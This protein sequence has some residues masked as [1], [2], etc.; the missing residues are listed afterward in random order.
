MNRFDF[1]KAMNGLTRKQREVLERFLTGQ[2]D[3][4][5]ADN[6]ICTK[7]NISKHISNICK[8]FGLSNGEGEYYSYRHELLDIFI[9]HQP[10]LVNP[11]EIQKRRLCAQEEP[12]FPGRGLMA[13]SRFYIQRSPIEKLS[14]VTIRQP[15]GLLRLHAA[16]RMGKTSLL[17]HLLAYVRKE[18]DY[19]TATLSFY[20]LEDSQLESLDNFLRWFC[21]TLSHELNLPSRVEDYWN[22]QIGCK[23]SCTRYIE[24]Y[25]LAKIDAPLV[26]SMDDVDRL[27]EYPTVAV[28]FFSLVRGWSEESRMRPIW[29]KFRQIVSYSTD[30]YIDFPL[31]QSPFN[32]G[33]QV[34]FP[35]FDVHQV[36]VLAQRYGGARLSR[37]GETE[38]E[39]L[40]GLVEGIPHLIQLALYHI[41][42]EEIFLV[43]LL[44]GAQSAMRI[45]NNHLDSLLSRLERH[46]PLLTALQEV[47]AAKGEPVRIEHSL[48]K[49][50]TGLGVVRPVGWKV[51]M[52]CRIYQQYFQAQW[53]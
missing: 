22:K 35:P 33:R 47:V 25:I 16:R 29:Q 49:R 46:T 5:I 31:N 36:M 37:L 38:A 44:S 34:D 14:Q 1:K 51:A 32:V 3:A 50:L 2:S 48:A 27:F 6:I 11:D 10:D 53:S 20:R 21:E 23:S 15:G 45:Y 19:K 42:T 17:Y 40:L 43:D 13:G 30:V 24:N 8:V 41:Y 28:G 9:D 4:E 12:P 52:G 39:A 26:I 7:N 18:L